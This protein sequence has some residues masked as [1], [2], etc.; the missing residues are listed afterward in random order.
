MESRRV[1]S[2]AGRAL[3]FSLLLFGAL[4]A[5][6][7]RASAQGGVPLWTNYYDG[8]ANGNDYT[9]GIGVDGDGNVFV[10]G[11]STNSI[12]GN[13]YVTVAYSSEGVPLWTN[14]HNGPANGSDRANA[15]VVDTNADVFVT[16]SAVGTNGFAFYATVAYS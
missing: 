7:P 5:L 8:Q 16:G 15:V 11:Y 3:L 1:K 6:A 12:T 10:T 2:T 14:R 9:T 13:D 4:A